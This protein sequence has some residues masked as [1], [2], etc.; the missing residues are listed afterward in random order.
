MSL[1]PGQPS[2][3]PYLSKS[4]RRRYMDLRSPDLGPTGTSASTGACGMPPSSSSTCWL[5][6]L[7]SGF[8]F[9]GE[10]LIALIRSPS[11]CCPSAWRLTTHA[12][13]SPLSVATEAALELRACPS[14]MPCLP[15]FLQRLMPAPCHF[16]HSVEHRLSE[17]DY[18]YLAFAPC[19]SLVWGFL[20]PVRTEPRQGH[21]SP[22]EK[23]WHDGLIRGNLP[24]NLRLEIDLQTR[25]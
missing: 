12:L 6:S 21:G 5:S 10:P 11:H 3:N 20:V 22:T 19:L 7:A 18:I 24:L 13:I 14:Q 2:V 15:A 9:F 4:W 17:W 25:A 1:H 16:G 8:Q 23:P